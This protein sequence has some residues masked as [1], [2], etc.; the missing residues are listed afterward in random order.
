MQTLLVNP[1]SSGDW[2][3]TR[4]EL[5]SNASLAALCDNLQLRLDMVFAAGKPTSDISDWRKATLVEANIGAIAIDSGWEAVETVMIRFGMMVMYI[6]A[7]PSRVSALART[8]DMVLQ[9][10]YITK[11]LENSDAQVPTA[12]DAPAEPTSARLVPCMTFRERMLARLRYLGVKHHF[13]VKVPGGS[14]SASGWRGQEPLTTTK[15][16]PHSACLGPS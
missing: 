5:L 1:A 7:T 8:I 4:N 6:S 15:P 10:A 3:V 13:P 12:S 11:A 9:T 16:R 2:D 14:L